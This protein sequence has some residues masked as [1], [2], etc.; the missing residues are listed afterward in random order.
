MLFTTTNQRNLMCGS[1]C[2]VRGYSRRQPKVSGTHQQNKIT[3]LDLKLHH[4]L[5]NSFRF[6]ERA[7]D[8]TW[9]S[10]PVSNI[11]SFKLS[12]ILENTKKSHESRSSGGRRTTVIWFSVIPGWWTQ[13]RHKL[14]DSPS[15]VLES[16][17]VLNGDQ[18]MFSQPLERF[19]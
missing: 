6:R 13:L 11:R 2:L 10:L 16:H 14:C 1:M 5:Q 3:F 18:H 7:S 9:M 15:H 17:S 19:K 12:F 4:H 8:Y